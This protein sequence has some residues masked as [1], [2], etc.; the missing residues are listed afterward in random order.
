MATNSKLN[1]FKEVMETSVGNLDSFS[2]LQTYLLFLSY[3]NKYNVDNSLLDRAIK[4]AKNLFHPLNKDD[5]LVKSIK[6]IDDLNLSDEDYEDLALSTLTANSLR[7]FDNGFDYNIS[8]LAIKLLQIKSSDTVYDLGSG[9]GGFLS[10]ASKLGRDEFSRP[11]VIGDEINPGEVEL[12]EII[13]TMCRANFKI[14]VTNALNNLKTP[15]FTKAYAFPP[16]GTN[17]K[18]EL[19][20]FNTNKNIFNSRTSLEWGFI[21]KLI[22][23]MPKDGKVVAL[24]PEFILFKN[25]DKEIREFIVSNKY[26]EGLISLPSRAVKWTGIKLYMAIFS[27][28]NESFKYFDAEKELAKYSI[29]DLSKVSTVETIFNLYNNV[30]QRFTIKDIN[31]IDFDLTPSTIANTKLNELIKDG[32]KL[33]DICEINRG[34]QGTISKFS[35]VITSEATG[36]KILTSSNIENGLINFDQL[37]SIKEGEKYDKFTLKKGDMVVTTKSTTVKFAVLLD[38]PK[39]K[40]IVTGGMYFIRPISNKIDSTFLKIFFESKLGKGIISSCLK[41]T[42]IK[43]LNY[44]QFS[45]IRVPCPSIAKQKELSKK[46]NSLLLVYDGLKQELDATSEKL[47][48]FYEDNYQEE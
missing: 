12:S 40:I 18:N 6:R 22:T 34:E 39:D 3:S 28:N 10:L 29:R 13:L 44:T 33:S 31:P 19:V 35:D 14:N 20:K 38:E 23:N 25:Y 17:S 5:S 41:G 32:V 45:E 24:I 2:S 48:S 8:F 7:Y 15:E 11:R 26:L 21:Y 46:Y 9:N 36:Y 30:Q 42:I 47:N 4:T 1:L 16:F 37:K 27:N 43:A